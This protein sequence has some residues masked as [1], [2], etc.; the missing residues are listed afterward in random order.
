MT[1]SVACLWTKQ[2]IVHRLLSIATL[3]S[4]SSRQPSSHFVILHAMT[5]HLAEVNIARIL[6]PLESPVM[7]DFVAQLESI[8]KLADNAP[9]FVW[10]LQGD[11]GDATSIRAF[12]DDKI[13][14]NMSVWKTIDALF[15]Y[16]YYSDHV[17]VF[18]ERR[19][20][21]EQLTEHILVLWWVPAGHIPTT[22]E[23][24]ERLEALRRDGPTAF[25]FTFKERFEAP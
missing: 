12:D 16:T 3:G 21:F 18:R 2:T 8:N 6:A 13:I 10:R 7:A 17:K 4:L 15:N 14:V 20:W 9:G 23:A 5:Y 24:K 25:A 22:A 1:C 19:K 11:A